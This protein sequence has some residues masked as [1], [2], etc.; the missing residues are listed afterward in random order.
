M[1]PKLA[2]VTRV[3]GFLIGPASSPRRGKHPVYDVL[4]LGEINADLILGDGATPAFGQAETLVDDATLTMGSSGVI[5]ACGAARLGLSVGYCGVV[6]DDIF[7]RF[8]LESLQQRSVDPAGVI[9]DKQVKTGL[10]V[11]LN[12][13]DDRAILTHLGS[14][15]S[16]SAEAIDRTLLTHTRHVHVTSYF[17]QHALQ[18]GL[19]QVL[20][21]ARAAGATVSMDT[22]WDP[23]EQWNHGLAL[24]LAE[25]DIFLP[26]ANEARAIAHEETLEAAE[27][28]LTQEI[29][30][31]VVK[32]GADGAHYCTKSVAIHDA[33]FPAD[34]VDTTGAGDSFDA[35][36]VY[37]HVHGW[38]A[39][40]SLALACACGALSTRAAGGTQA[41]PTLQEALTLIHNRPTQR[42]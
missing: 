12:D 41:Q 7:G 9:V 21:E 5:F 37:G 29:C 26:N 39:E 42:Q 32:L 4:V 28:K 8:M 3:N 15:N 2:N 19:P 34:V 11:I 36:F 25:T 18:P 17:L 23:S 38:A 40:D 27:K 30:T 16:L 31:V 24:A 20:S 10:S 14:I 33:G 6:G 1:C 22:N 13:K 35:G